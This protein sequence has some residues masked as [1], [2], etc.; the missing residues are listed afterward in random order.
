M[1]V[2]APFCPVHGSAQRGPGTGLPGAELNWSIT[3]WKPG[4]FS[5]RGQVGSVSSQVGVCLLGWRATS[6]WTLGSGG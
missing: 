5:V 2:S 6:L 4:R 1:W 3:R